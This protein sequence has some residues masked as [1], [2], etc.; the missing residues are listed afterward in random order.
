MLLK[1][2]IP[3]SRRRQLKEIVALVRFLKGSNQQSKGH[4]HTEFCGYR[5]LIKKLSKTV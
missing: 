1:N 5:P 3:A 2:A 4:S